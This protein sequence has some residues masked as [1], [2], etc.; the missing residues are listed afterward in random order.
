MNLVKYNPGDFAHD[1]GATVQHGPQNLS[2]HNQTGRGGV[3]G[4]ITR[5]ES[6]IAELSHELSVLLVTE[7]LDRAGV[8][9]SLVVLQ[10][11]RNGVLGHYCLSC[12]G[13]RRD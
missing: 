10:T 11:L 13:M 8:D 6:N 9:D 12:G 3:D 7:R 2:G 1:L 5:H 4:D